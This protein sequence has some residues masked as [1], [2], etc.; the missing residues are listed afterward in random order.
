MDHL[1][2]E[3]KNEVVVVSQTPDDEM[4]EKVAEMVL[5]QSLASFRKQQLLKQIDQ[6]LIDQ[7]ESTF[8]ELTNQYNM[9]LSKHNFLQ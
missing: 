4:Y 2:K 8:I 1:N 3:Q 5:V 6:S 7:D 9:L